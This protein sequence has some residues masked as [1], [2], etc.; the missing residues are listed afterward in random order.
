[1]KCNEINHSDDFT[2]ETA[3]LFLERVFSE[4]FNVDNDPCNMAKKYMTPDYLQLV[5]GKSLH[6]NEFVEHLG[7]V[8]NEFQSI[9]FTFE[10]VIASGNTISDIHIVDAIK[11]D[12]SK[13]KAKVIAFFFIR[14]GKIFKIDE[15]TTLLEGKEEDKDLGSRT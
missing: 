7:V 12:G 4:L 2:N 3:K 14:N 1:M 11:N 15:L 5:D 6:Y 10:Q 9:N 8:L 13:F